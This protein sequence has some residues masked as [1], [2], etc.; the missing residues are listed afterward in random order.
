MIETGALYGGEGNGGV[1]VKNFNFT[2]DGIF[3]SLLILSLLC[4]LG[5]PREFK[6]I[7]RP[8]YRLK[9]KFPLQEKRVPSVFLNFAE[10]INS[11]SVEREDGI[12]VKT[13][14]GFIHIRVSNTEPVL[15]VI[16]EAREK[17]VLEEWKKKIEELV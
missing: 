10:N 14:E 16:M 11:I 5:D 8:R 13:E 9:L 3:A 1:I 12:R 2:R 17:E 6:K 15:R 4:E 7:K